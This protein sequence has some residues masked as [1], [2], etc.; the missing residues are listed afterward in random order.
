MCCEKLPVVKP[1][2]GVTMAYSLKTHFV[3]DLS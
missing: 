3:E 1:G 2:M